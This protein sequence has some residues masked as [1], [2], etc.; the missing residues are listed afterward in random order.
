MATLKGQ[1]LI[2][3]ATLL[4]PNF[5][6]TVVLVAEHGD[7][8][9]MGLVLNRPS[10][11]AVWDAVPHLESLVGDTEPVFVGGPVEPAAVVVLAEF[12]DAAEAASVVFADVG[13]VAGDADPELLVGA[14]RRTR[15]FAGYAGWA[16]GQLE[17]ELEESAWIVE[18]A[19]V[20]DVFSA[21]SDRL[22][23]SVLRRK[24]GAY[25][26]L[27]LMPPDPTVN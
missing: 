10:P 2:A 3:S 27:A 26:V 5:K 15:V 18:P 17:A 21:A 7:D 13:F 14:T 6:Q 25:A 11:A 1:L 9:A 20:D 22:W 16:A 23:S 8:G 4:D 24:G 12:D 19:T